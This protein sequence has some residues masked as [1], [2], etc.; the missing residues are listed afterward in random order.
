ML[1]HCLLCTVLAFTLSDAAILQQGSCRGT[2]TGLVGVAMIQ[3]QPRKLRGKRQTDK[4]KKPNPQQTVVKY[5]R[6]SGQTT[7]E[8]VQ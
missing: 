6:N 4:Q 3:G 7:A 2:N 1:L 5:I 8:A